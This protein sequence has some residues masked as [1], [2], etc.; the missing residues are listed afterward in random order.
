MVIKFR[1][2]MDD[3]RDE[4]ELGVPI[5]PFPPSLED[6]PGDPLHDHPFVA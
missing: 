6:A 5:H 4:G 2:D 1:Q 3:R